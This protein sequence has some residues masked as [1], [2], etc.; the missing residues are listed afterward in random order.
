MNA[1]MGNSRQTGATN[2][3]WW[4]EG[5]IPGRWWAE[6]LISICVSRWWAE[7]PTMIRQSGGELKG[8]SPV[9]IA[10]AMLPVSCQDVLCL[11]G[12]HVSQYVCLPMS[13]QCLLCWTV[14]VSSLVCIPQ[15]SI[16]MTRDLHNKY[17]YEC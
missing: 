3:R 12:Q 13:C 1:N 8:V 16:A 15:V 5:L 10:R 9:C 7:G 17:Y 14:L 4:A 11:Q 6:G 2:I